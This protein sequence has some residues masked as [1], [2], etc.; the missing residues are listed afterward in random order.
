MHAHWSETWLL[1][2]PG[3]VFVWT[4]AWRLIRATA[5]DGLSCCFTSV[6]S[7]GDGI[8]YCQHH[9]TREPVDSVRQ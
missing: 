7:A 9:T 2:L 8:S 6:G 5:N 4:A 1:L 3:M